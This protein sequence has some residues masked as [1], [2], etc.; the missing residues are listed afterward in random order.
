[1]DLKSKRQQNDGVINDVHESDIE[2][3]K[4]VYENALFVADYLGWDAVICD[5]NGQMRSIED[6]HNDVMTKVKKL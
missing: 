6:I 1:M 4:K 2:F 3:M 5:S